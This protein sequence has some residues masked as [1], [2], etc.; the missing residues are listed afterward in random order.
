MPSRRAQTGEGEA[1]RQHSAG[2]EECEKRSS[3]ANTDA[4]NC[5]CGMGRNKHFPKEWH[6]SWPCRMT[7]AS[8]GTGTVSGICQDIVVQK[9][10]AYSED[11][12]R[13]MRCGT[14]GE[15]AISLETEVMG[16]KAGEVGIKVLN[17]LLKSFDFILQIMKK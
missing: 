14:W 10:T 4:V 7:R 11:D 9:A 5:P 2:P 13:F 17:A 12:K 16:E 1:K 6:L 3:S 8:S 15:L